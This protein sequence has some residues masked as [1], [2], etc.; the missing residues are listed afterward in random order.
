MPSGPLGGGQGPNNQG[1]PGPFQAGPGS[2]P[3]VRGPP[4]MR[5]PSDMRGQG[6]MRGDM[7][8]PDM[9]GGPQDMMRG[10]PDMRQDMRGPGTVSPTV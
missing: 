1:P 3:D 2:A 10:P 7:R 6:D 8:G 5:G 9:R 4:E